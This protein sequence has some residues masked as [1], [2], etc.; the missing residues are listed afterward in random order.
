MDWLGGF[1]LFFQKTSRP[2]LPVN[3]ER[4]ISKT[5]ALDYN[6]IIN[7]HTVLKLYYKTVFS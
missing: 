3:S 4:V 2:P 6:F 7:L 1:Y 5:S